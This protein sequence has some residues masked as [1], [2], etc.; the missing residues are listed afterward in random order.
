[1]C[2][3]EPNSPNINVPRNTSFSFISFFRE[4]WINESTLFTLRR[5]GQGH[6]AF[7]RFAHFAPHAA[8]LP[9]ILLR[10]L[11]EIFLQAGSFDF[12]WMPSAWLETT[13]LPHR[14][15]GSPNTARMRH[16]SG[17]RG[18]TK[19]LEVVKDILD[20][21]VCYNEYLPCRVQLAIVIAFHMCPHTMYSRGTVSKL[22]PMISS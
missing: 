4:T 6:L 17:R 14:L 3:T 1:M 15:R 13:S 20:L 12:P 2:K 10:W 19:S 7:A 21:V 22:N 18:L 11:R 5:R 8:P 16:V 9:V